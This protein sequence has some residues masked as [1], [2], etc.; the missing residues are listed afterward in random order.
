MIAERLGGTIV[1]A[2]FW[3]PKLN[4]W[5]GGY[6]SYANT[7]HPFTQIQ[8]TDKGFEEMAK[9]VDNVRS[10]VGYNIPLSTD[11]YGHFDL[12][13]GIRLGKA[14]E[15]YRLAWLEADLYDPEADGAR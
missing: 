10:M 11:H 1:N 15:K 8:I 14:L 2:E 6:M 12:N 3:G 5:E 7:E 9:I 13:N 4:Q